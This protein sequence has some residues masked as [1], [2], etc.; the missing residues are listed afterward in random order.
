MQGYIASGQVAGVILLERNVRSPEQLSALTAALRAASPDLPPII[1]IDQEGGMIARLGPKNGFSSWASP[2]E[3][4]RQNPS[5]TEILDYYRTRAGE[6]AEAGIN[7]NFGPVVDLNLNPTNPIIGGL[8]RSYGVTADAVL[9]FAEP[10]VRAHRAA[11][12]ATCLKHFPGHGSSTD[13]SH[14]SL[15]DISQTWSSDELV[16]FRRMAEEGLADAIMMGHLMLPALTDDPWL[17][18]SLSRRAVTSIREDIGLDGPVITDDMQMGAI[19]ALLDP[20]SAAIAAVNAGNSLQ[21]YANFRRSHRIE[22]VQVV[23][24]A[25]NV[26]ADQGDIDVEQAAMQLSIMR[27]FRSRL[28]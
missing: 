23:G 14:E 21:I 1:S 3:L 12:I 18:T 6:L 17:P 13:D 26:A 24:A 7:L 4:A 10:F 16:P 9:R 22:T 2:A 5:D 8:G 28:S 25:L 20:A 11:G 15:P 27:A 19:S